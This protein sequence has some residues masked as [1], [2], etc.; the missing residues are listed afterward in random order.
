MAKS[1]KPLLLICVLVSVFLISGCN[2][3]DVNAKTDATGV[4]SQ[5]FTNL[6]RL[7]GSAIV[8]LVV[9]GSPITMTIDGASAPI[10]AGNFVDLVQ[11]GFYDGLS[12]HRVVKDPNPFVVQGGDPQSKDPNVPSARLGTGGY[13][14]ENGRERTIPLEILPQDGKAPIYSTTFPA[15][16]ITVP[17]QLTHKRGAVAMA[18]SQYPDS[19]SS[20]FYITL[21]DWSFLDGNYAVFAYVTEGMD[22]VDRIAQGDRIDSARVVS[23]AENLKLP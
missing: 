7:E 10:T 18:R 12:F 8:Q 16:G 3:G 21:A 19:A 17:P 1:F 2:R 4:T 23:G 5:S 22:V 13:R 6:P 14:D 15:A 11:K 9:K 20:Q